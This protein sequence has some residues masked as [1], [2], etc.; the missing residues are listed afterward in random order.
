MYV[1]TFT[2]LD[3]LL[4]RIAL[5]ALHLHLCDAEED[6]EREQRR[7]RAAFYNYF[8]DRKWGDTA[9]Y[10]LCLDTGRVTPEQAVA[11]NRA[12]ADAAG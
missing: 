10:D 7:R 9:T 5:V 1:G 6:G 11:V 8:T 4:V 3:D 12:Y 2:S